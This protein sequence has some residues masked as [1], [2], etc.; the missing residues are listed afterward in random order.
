[1]IEGASRKLLLASCSGNKVLKM[2]HL[3]SLMKEEV[4]Q[5]FRE[6]GRNLQREET[7]TAAP[8]L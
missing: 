3:P 8:M 1:V 5:M 2:L 7:A 6:F 4:I